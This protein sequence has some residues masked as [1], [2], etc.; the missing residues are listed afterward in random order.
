[1]GRP[2]KEIDANVFFD[3]LGSGFT[4]KQMAESLGVS[5]PT[6][7]KRIADLQTR[8]GL[9]LKY[10]EVQHLQLTDMQARILEAIT[11]EKIA[12]ASLS[13]LV[14]AFRILKDKELVVNGKPSEIRGLVGY[15]VEM[16]KREF[17]KVAVT[18]ADCEIAEAEDAEYEEVEDLPKL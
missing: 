9:L 16:E 11:P 8:T 17:E 14:S 15:L 5:V 6:L 1:M 2:T 3:M 10:R 12:D 4:Q 18:A 7:E 13:E